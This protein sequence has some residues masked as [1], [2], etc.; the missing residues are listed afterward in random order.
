MKITGET[1]VIGIFGYPVRHSLSPLM[2]NAAIEALGLNYIY[3]PFEV[4]PEELERAVNGIRALGI[5]GVNITI[6]HK[7]K[8]VPFLEEVTEEASLIGSVNTIENKNGR[9]IGHNTDSRGYIRSLREDAGFEPKGKKILVI[10][11]GGAARGIIAGLS[12]ND[13][14]DIFIANRTVE[15]G[16]RLALEFK[17]KFSAIRFSS[18][19]LSSLKDPNILSQV[20]LIVNASSMGLDEGAP[21]VEFSLT[22][23]HALISDIVYKPAVTPFLKKAQ[24]AGRKTLG[25]L[26]M[27]I[28]Q[29]AI[30][31]E[32]WTSK[33]APVDIMRNSLTPFLSPCKP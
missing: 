33:E 27:L 19:P 26:G 24:A 7:E 12:M 6:P 4:K 13:A 28:Y 31:L 25:G 18:I 8:V 23:P 11:A 14:S 29:G 21:D 22:P 1:K 5:S 20:D 15:K 17:D 32:I 10:G 3:I 2:Q 30:S 16:E 9:L